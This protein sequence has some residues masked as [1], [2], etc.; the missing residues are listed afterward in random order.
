MWFAGLPA[1]VRGRK[2]E[3][4]KQAGDDP[5]AESG[6][7]YNLAH[8]AAAA[9]SFPPKSAVQNARR[10]IFQPKVLCREATAR[11]GDR[12][13]EISEAPPRRQ[14]L[15]I[16]PPSAQPLPAPVGRGKRG[17]SSIPPRF[18]RHRRRFSGIPA[19]VCDTTAR[20]F[21]SVSS[22]HRK[23]FVGLRRGPHKKEAS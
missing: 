1:A 13:G 22:P 16:G 21:R 3:A 17:P 10:F 14:K 4:V 18:I 11:M 7:G 8:T 12:E 6:A 2:L 15:H 19:A 5:P 9:V 20:P 23:H